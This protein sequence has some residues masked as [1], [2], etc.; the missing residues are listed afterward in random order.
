MDA[1]QHSD[2][3]R[4]VRL[5]VRDAD[6]AERALTGVLGAWR[7]RV[8]VL[9]DSPDP[10]QALILLERIAESGA[11]GRAAVDAAADDARLA[12]RLV[13]LLG[14]SVALGEH[15]ARHPGHLEDLRS[16]DVAIPDADQMRHAVLECVSATADHAEALV[17]LRIAYRRMLLSIACLDLEGVVGLDVVGRALADAADAVLDGALFIAR[18]QIPESDRIR[19]SVIAMGKCGARELNYIS[20]VDVIFVCEPMPGVEET[21]ALAIGTRVARD[22]MTA[23][24][25]HTPEGAIWEVDAALRPE[26]KNGALVRTLA[27]HVAYY[28]RFASTWEFQALLKARPAAGDAD[29]GAAYIDAIAPF[30]WSAADRSDFVENA[31]AMRRRVEENIPA[32]EAARQLKLGV[33]GLRDVEFSVQLLQLVHGRSDAML[34]RPGTL[35]ALEALATWGYI[36]RDDMTQLAGA[37]RF[38]RS[39]EHRIQLHRL[40]RTH[41]VPE[42]A[43]DLRR[44]GRAMGFTA[45]PEVALISQWREH[46]RETRRIH[47]KLFYRP[48]LDAVS[49]LSASAARLTPEAAASRLEALGYRDPEGALRHLEALTSGV[50]RRAAIQRTLLPVMLGWFADGAD[51]DAGLLGFRR[52]SDALG[53]THWY[54]RLLRD[55][56]AAAERLARVLASSRYATDLL[57][58][59]PEAVSLLADDDE[60]L[61]R[62]LDVL[63]AEMRAIASRHEDPTAAVTAVRGLRRRELFRVS[64]A[65]VLGLLDVEQVAAGLTAITEATLGITLEVCLRSAEERHGAPLPMRFLLVAMGRLGGGELGYGSDADVMFVFDPE[66][67][68]D[69]EAATRVAFEVANDLRTVLMVPSTDPPLEVDAD[70]R[71]EGRQGA[72]VRSLASYAAYYARWS[73]SWESQALL[74]ARPIAGDERLA[75]QFLDLI[76]PLRWPADGLPESALLEIRRLKARMENERLPRGADPTLHTKLGRGGLSDVEWV[77]QVLQ[78]RH[79]HDVPGLRT[80][81]TLPALRAAVAAGYLSAE[82]SVALEQAWRMATHVRNAMVLLRAK[83]A[84]LLV[85][86]PVEASA[87]ARVLGFGAGMGQE[88]IDTYRRTTRRARQV[89]ERVFYGLPDPTE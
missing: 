78:L 80:T 38:L 14:M 12:H 83:P 60:L 28:E 65:D 73:A 49:R 46:Q 63:T 70:L 85:T 75:H 51:P 82:D 23:C 42:D 45:E 89:M 79:A 72:L 6:R 48:L 61:P 87:V 9:G 19:L 69:E 31:R 37:Y 64:A 57:L 15:L 21:E 4:L 59:A 3:A 77:A 68:A 1:R 54:L 7:D 56:S 24:S 41:V 39:F 10:D 25:A 52:V 86:D 20:D 27:S 36:G 26:G 74:R 76:E 81:L 33:G 32:K 22:L 84:D 16:A 66:P 62:S 30:V 58:R 35:E 8:D 47:E 11:Q 53:S 55:E 17:A 67:A 2:R 34:R 43:D 44:I 71:P 29:L 88:M 18:R 13:R 40:R 5:G 50:S